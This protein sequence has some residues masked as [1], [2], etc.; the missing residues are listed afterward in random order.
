MSLTKLVTHLT[1]S[2]QVDYVNMSNDMAV[3]A[4]ENF[5]I[6]N[7][8]AQLDMLVLKMEDSVLYVDLMGSA[9]GAGLFNFNFGSERSFIKRTTKIILDYCASQQTEVVILKN[10]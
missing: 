9:G 2:Y 8:S 3:L 6:R 4:N 1:T 5:Y 10:A 7:N